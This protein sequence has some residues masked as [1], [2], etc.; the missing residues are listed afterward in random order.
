LRSPRRALTLRKWRRRPN[1]AF[2]PGDDGDGE[3]QLEEGKEGDDDVQ[4]ESQREAEIRP[5]ANKSERA[6]PIPAR[7]GSGYEDRVKEETS[8]KN[9]SLHG[10]TLGSNDNEGGEG[11][12]QK[13]K[14]S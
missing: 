4:A 9:V 14:R 5:V 13:T 1:E 2:E 8:R 11:E 6:T 12:R 7:E 10:Q 3:E